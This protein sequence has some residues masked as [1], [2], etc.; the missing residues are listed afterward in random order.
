MK[1]RKLTALLLCL[2]AVGMMTFNGCKKKEALVDSDTSVATDD[3]LVQDETNNVLNA[4]NTTYHDQSGSRLQYNYTLLPICAHVTGINDST[5][6]IDSLTLPHTIIIDFGTS[7][8]YCDN[9]DK[10]Y[11]KGQ[12]IVTWTG[13]FKDSN[14][15]VTV[16]TKDYS[17]STDNGISYDSLH[18]TATITNNG[19]NALHHPVHTIHAVDTCVTNTGKITWTSDCVVE[20]TGGY[21]YPYPVAQQTFSMTGTALGVSR[22]GTPFNV[23]ITSPVEF[24]LS[25]Q[26]TVVRGTLDINIGTGA[27][28]HVD[29]G[30]GGCDNDA[31]VD[32]DGTIYNIKI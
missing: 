26:Y 19:T 16:I 27:T 32:I 12:I 11:R 20:W 5:G 29:F 3:A 25:C 22:K 24:D 4:A 30:N 18:L 31:T 8:C 23:N 10:K 2:L 9:W 28:R 1:K 21:A 7:G 13:R 17:V 15:V 14:N 6:I